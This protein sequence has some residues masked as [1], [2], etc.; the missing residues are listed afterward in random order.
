M[1]ANPLLAWRLLREAAQRGHPGAQTEVG[2]RLATGTLPESG[3]LLELRAPRW[4]EAAVHLY[5]GAAGNDTLAQARI[6]A[7]AL[8]RTTTRR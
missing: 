4:R 5:F 2:L 8:P 1:P 7:T 3:G 6:R